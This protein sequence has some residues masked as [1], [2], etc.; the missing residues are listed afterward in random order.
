M[1][2]LGDGPPLLWNPQTG[3]F[4]TLRTATTF[5][6]GVLAATTG[7]ATIWTPSAGKRFRLLGILGMTLTNVAA[8]V[9]AEIGVTL[10]DQG[11]STGIAWNFSVPAAAP[12]P[13]ILGCVQIVP[14][15]DLPGNGYLS[16]TIGNAL[17]LNVSTVLSAGTIR[18]AVAGT[19]E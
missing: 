1:G 13:T 18:C 15:F 14:P 8:G 7:N 12:A 16:S 5:R 19:E 17:V 10:F 6:T 4:E 11:A 9:T 2:K 3:A